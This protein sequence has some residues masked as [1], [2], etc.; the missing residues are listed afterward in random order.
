MPSWTSWSPLR[1]AELW[2]HPRRLNRSCS[3]NSLTRRGDGNSGKPWFK[4]K[5]DQK[6]FKSK[7]WRND[8]RLLPKFSW[9]SSSGW[10]TSGIRRTWTPRRISKPSDN[11]TR[12]NKESAKRFKRSNTTGIINTWAV[13]ANKAT[14]GSKPKAATTQPNSSSRTTYTM[15]FRK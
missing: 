4:R 12:N 5:S 15:S 6:R 3:S 9:R 14:R 13:W 11:G 1:D 2:R 7:P 8:W 10:I